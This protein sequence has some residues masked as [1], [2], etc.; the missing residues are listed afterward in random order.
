MFDKNKISQQNLYYASLKKDKRI[1]EQIDET[2]REKIANDRLQAQMDQ[3]KLE[4]FEKKKKLQQMLYN[5][6]NNYLKQKYSTPPENREQLNIKVG[7]EQRR[8][9]KMNYNEEMDNLCLNPTHQNIP[10]TPANNYS[11]MGRKYQ[12]GYSHGYNIITGE[13]YKD[14]KPEIKKNE[15]ELN[16]KKEDDNNFKTIKV[17]PEEYEEFLKF[18]EMKRLNEQNINKDSN[19]NDI[20]SI[21]KYYNKEDYNQ[22]IQESNLNYQNEKLNQPPQTMNQGE[23]NDMRERNQFIRTPKA[24]FHY[25]QLRK[26]PNPQ[27]QIYNNKQDEYYN[28]PQHYQNDNIPEQKNEYYPNYQMSD[29]NKNE[30]YPNKEKLNRE[31]EQYY[32]QNYPN[33]Y[34]NQISKE[35]DM[36]PYNNNTNINNNMDIPLYNQKEMMMNQNNQEQEDIHFN[37]RIPYQ[38]NQNYY[39]DEQ[40]EYRP[41]SRMENYPY[42]QNQDNNLPPDDKYEREKYMQYL[43]NKSKEEKESNIKSTNNNMNNEDN[44]RVDNYPNPNLEYQRNQTP[45][46][47]N[48]YR[49][50]EEKKFLVKNEQLPQYQYNNYMQQNKPEFLKCLSYN[51]QVKRMKEQENYYKDMKN[52]NQIPPNFNSK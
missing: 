11:D 44:Y 42:Q 24:N 45:Y 34:N 13:M 25:E 18:K 38:N 30:F 33:Q 12:R 28:K 26:T 32:E 23:Y 46:N 19:Y 35:K 1:Q 20:Q 48:Y 15:N 10:K 2:R 14:K 29:Y 4:Q 50:E 22:D 3:E 27:E 52:I 9:K 37:E 47:N 39:Q 7:G 36:I 31:E 40:N 17:S 49:N 5:D 16:Y 41:K 8:I 51:E 21:P 43:I 6:Y